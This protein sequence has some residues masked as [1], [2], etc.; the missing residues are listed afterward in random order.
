MFNII[1]AWVDVKMKFYVQIQKDIIEQGGQVRSLKAVNAKA[2]EALL[3]F[4]EPADVVD[5]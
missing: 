4:G 2:L 1:A 3:L 5:R